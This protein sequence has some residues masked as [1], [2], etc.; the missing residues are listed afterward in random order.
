MRGR[1]SAFDDLGVWAVQNVRSSM[2]NATHFNEIL[3][4]YYMLKDN[5]VY[6]WHD[7]R[8]RLS[9]FKENDFLIN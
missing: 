1:K 5:D 8:W 3:G 4:M 2:S 7:N 9:A 6:M